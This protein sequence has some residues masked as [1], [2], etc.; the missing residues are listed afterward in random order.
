MSTVIQQ[1]EHDFIAEAKEAAEKKKEHDKPST[2]IVTVTTG[3]EN[4]IN[5][6]QVSP[7]AQMR[8]FETN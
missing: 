5:V 6:F 3:E 8:Q 2:S 7:V 4:D 1:E